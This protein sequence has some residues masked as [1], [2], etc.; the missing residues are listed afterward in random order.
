[1]G[2]SLLLIKFTVDGNDVAVAFGLSESAGAK[3]E[4]VAWFDFRKVSVL[5]VFGASDLDNFAAFVDKIQAEI[6][7][8]SELAVSIDDKANVGVGVIC[9]R[10][11]R[12]TV[13]EM[14]EK[15]RL[16]YKYLYCPK[17]KPNKEKICEH[18]IMEIGTKFFRR[19]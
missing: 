7:K 14:N 9:N 4:F 6:A 13:Y 12:H 1:M 11:N 10:E 16:A 5:E 8:R 15:I 2:C 17:V 18:V 3:D 19:V